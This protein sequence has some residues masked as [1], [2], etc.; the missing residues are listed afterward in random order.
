[1]PEK[2]GLGLRSRPAAKGA[3]VKSLQSALDNIRDYAEPDWRRKDLML[4]MREDV[5]TIQELRPTLPSEQR[6]QHIPYGLATEIRDYV[7]FATEPSRFILAVLE[8]KL[9]LALTEAS[10]AEMFYLHA[11]MRFIVAYVPGK[12]WGSTKA[13]SEWLASPGL[14]RFWDEYD[15]L[16]F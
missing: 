3:T 2:A 6:E 16:P 10:E 8:D 14:P 5:V 11:V 1:M 4:V 13:V 7:Q 15:S 9:L 12:S